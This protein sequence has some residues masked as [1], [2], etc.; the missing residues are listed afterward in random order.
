MFNFLSK[1]LQKIFVALNYLTNELN[2]KVK[3][4][5][6]DVVNT[7]VYSINIDMK[8]NYVLNQVPHFQPDGVMILSMKPLSKE[9]NLFQIKFLIVLIMNQFCL[10][11]ISTVDFKED[12]SEVSKKI[13]TKPLTS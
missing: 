1:N 4:E 12:A 6:I 2:I 13:K 7:I 11:K 5:V 3:M 9:G 8:K 10:I